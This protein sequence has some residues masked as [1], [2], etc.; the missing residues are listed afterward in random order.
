MLFG[1]EH[2]QQ[3]ILDAAD[4]IAR[5]ENFK[6][7]FAASHRSVSNGTHNYTSDYDERY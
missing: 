1:K 6:L 3:Q 5:R 7:I 4:K 2:V